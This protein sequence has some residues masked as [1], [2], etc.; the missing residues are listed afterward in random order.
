MH[1]N[2]LTQSALIAALYLVLTITPPLNTIAYASIQFRISEALLILLFFKKKLL[3]GLVIG[4]FL[5]NLLGPLGGAFSLIDAGLGSLVT[6]LAGSW[7]VKQKHFWVGILAPILFNGIYLGLFLPF[8]LDLP[9][10]LGIFLA[11]GGSV[12]FGQLVV[13]VV[14]GFP[15]YVL[16]KKNPKLYQGGPR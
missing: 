9:K 14:L 1:V 6:Y 10:D 2:E 13:L 3:F 7:L 12:A 11:T 15:L 8:A 16:L 4:T 5:A